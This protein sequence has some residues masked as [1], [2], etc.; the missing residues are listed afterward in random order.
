MEVV[1]EGVMVL[2]LTL[3]WQLNLAFLWIK[4]LF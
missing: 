4:L 1:Q 3:R 2:N